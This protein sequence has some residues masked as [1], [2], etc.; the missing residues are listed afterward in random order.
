MDVPRLQNLGALSPRELS[1]TPGGAIGAWFVPF[2]NLVRPFQIVREI[3]WISS[4]PEDAE[5]ATFERVPRAPTVIKGWWGIYLA[6]GFLGQAVFR[7]SMSA[8]SI[9]DLL[10]SSYLSIAADLM[11]ILSAL[12]AI[13]VVRLISALQDGASSTTTSRLTPGT[14]ASRSPG[15]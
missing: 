8:K 1:F 12:L 10:A 11:G 13:Q 2:L 9:P 14:S 7:A 4:A 15:A 6:S 5:R 3:W